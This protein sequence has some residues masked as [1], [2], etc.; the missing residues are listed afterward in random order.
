M[1][2]GESGEVGC[3]EDGADGGVCYE[4]WENWKRCVSVCCCY[5]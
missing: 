2:G 1:E 4:R 3:V 5:T